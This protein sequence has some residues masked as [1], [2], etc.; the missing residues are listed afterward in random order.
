M[1]INEVLVCDNNNKKFSYKNIKNILFTYD[2]L[3]IWQKDSAEVIDT[4][5]SVFLIKNKGVIERLVAPPSVTE[6]VNM[7]NIPLEENTL[8]YLTIDGVLPE[9]AFEDCQIPVSL[10]S[11]DS[12]EP[13]ERSSNSNLSDSDLFVTYMVYATNRFNS[14]YS[15]PK[16]TQLGEASSYID[17]MLDCISRAN[18]TFS[19]CNFA[20][21]LHSIIDNLNTILGKAKSNPSKKLTSLWFNNMRV[22]YLMNKIQK[23]EKYSKLLKSVKVG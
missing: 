7:K 2:K 20:P 1:Y 14:L 5:G 16:D 21:T 23:D 9:L 11:E 3:I 10:C 12:K 4:R 22:R 18:T 19:S 8:Y 17:E 15:N 13:I 6:N